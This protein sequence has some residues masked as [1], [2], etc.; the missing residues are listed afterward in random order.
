MG[1]RWVTNWSY[2]ILHTLNSELT[3][4]SAI[5]LLMIFSAIT[6]AL[7]TDPETGRQRIPTE[8]ATVGVAIGHACMIWG[9]HIGR[10]KRVEEVGHS[11]GVKKKKAEPSRQ[12]R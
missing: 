8:F 1:W 4:P 6:G 9:F 12:Q 3:L 11:G 5:G 2:G 10:K 7:S